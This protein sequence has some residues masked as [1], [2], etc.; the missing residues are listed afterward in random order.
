MP[1]YHYECKDCDVAEEHYFGFSDNQ[2]VKCEECN[3]P[4]EKVIF[5]VGVIFR[6]TGWAGKK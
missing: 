1:F 6:G 3:E 4:M 5:P 2:E